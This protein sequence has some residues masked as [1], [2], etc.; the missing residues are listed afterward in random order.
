MEL[1]YKNS[2]PFEYKMYKEVADIA[3][4]PSDM[5]KIRGEF[6]CFFKKLEEGCAS[7]FD[8]G[9]LEKE[10][11]IISGH[12][13]ESI[14]RA[15]NRKSM[16]IRE[17]VQFIFACCYLLIDKYNLP[18]GKLA[19]IFG[20]RANDFSKLDI[21]PERSYHAFTKLKMEGRKKKLVPWSSDTLGI[22]IAECIN[23]KLQ[24]AYCCTG[25]IGITNDLDI[26]A[27]ISSTDNK[28]F[29]LTSPLEFEDDDAESIQRAN[30]SYARYIFAH[31]NML[32]NDEGRLQPAGRIREEIEKLLTMQDT[33]KMEE[34]MFR[35]MLVS[36]ADMKPYLR[37]AG[38]YD[39]FQRLSEE[40]RFAVETVKRAADM[41]R[42]EYNMAGIEYEDE[43]FGA[44]ELGDM[45]EVELES[46]R[47]EEEQYLPIEELIANYAKDAMGKIE[48]L[49]PELLAYINV[50]SLFR[51]DDSLKYWVDCISKWVNENVIA[52]DSPYA[53]K[54][55][56]AACFWIVEAFKG[57]EVSEGDIK[58]ALEYIKGGLLP[59]IDAL[60]APP[61]G[62]K[63]DIDE[64]TCKKSHIYMMPD[65]G[66][67]IQG[68]E[69]YVGKNLFPKGKQVRPVMLYIDTEAH[70]MNQQYL[71]GLMQKRNIL[72]IVHDRGAA[73]E[74]YGMRLIDKELQLY[75]MDAFEE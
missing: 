1:I 36:E 41:L 16:H 13:V 28:T 4:C 39:T 75:M 59:Y 70:E 19:S 33:L 34:R 58:E 20:L 46:R 5:G 60:N 66:D 52:T 50:R 18:Q 27:N 51:T 54:V 12:I 65:Q 31:G 49:E 42:S 17:E 14:R 3:I 57:R 11:E 56:A 6:N 43:H 47:D 45:E 25:F 2:V 73:A 32:F 67:L 22:K 38:E 35:E 55:K 71:S 15:G 62:K 63:E 72:V 53:V 8:I 9:A 29:I 74:E 64:R 30:Y 10:Y 44:Y 37:E 21:F 40:Y 23:R 69:K 24:A 68:F 61:S 7:D 26:F 48:N